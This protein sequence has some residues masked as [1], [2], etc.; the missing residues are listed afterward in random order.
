MMPCKPRTT[1][2]R[3]Q[4]GG[5][6]TVTAFASSH[7]LPE[8]PMK[9]WAAQTGRVHSINR[10]FPRT[11]LART[12]GT[13]QAA[14]AIVGMVSGSRRSRPVML[15][16]EPTQDADRNGQADWS[17]TSKGRSWINSGFTSGMTTVIDNIQS[18]A[19]FISDGGAVMRLTVAGSTDRRGTTPSAIMPD[20]PTSS[21]IMTFHAARLRADLFVVLVV[22]PEYGSST[23][24]AAVGL[25][26]EPGCQVGGRRQQL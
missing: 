16:S 19:T 17:E 24:R 18:D 10:G 20:T 25:S 13:T 6:L 22:M 9:T 1:P 2:T 3:R 11:F 26:Y 7:G 5:C 12:C 14:P 21:R 4:H 23:D 8:R 15:T